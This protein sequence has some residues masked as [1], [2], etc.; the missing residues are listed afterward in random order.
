MTYSS[1][2]FDGEPYGSHETL[3]DAQRRKID[4]LL[5]AAGGRRRAR[6]V[7][8]IGTGW[9]ELAHPRGRAAARTVTIADHLHRAGRT[10]PRAHRRRRARPTGSTVLL[11][12]YRE[13]A[14]HATTPSSA[15][16]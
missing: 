6:R 16:R 13:V 9:G 12:D 8:E 2:I 11:Q 7:L 14:G 1:A 10:G 4:R 3:A 15:S 5:D